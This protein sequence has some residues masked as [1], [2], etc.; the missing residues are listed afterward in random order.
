M[1]APIFPIDPL[2]HAIGKVVWRMSVSERAELERLASLSP[3]QRVLRLMQLATAVAKRDESAR[4]VLAQP[5]VVS[6]LKQM[7][8]D[9]KNEEAEASEAERQSLQS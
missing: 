3:V 2:D 9:R 4:A 8:I 1:Q 6:S 7:A 5:G